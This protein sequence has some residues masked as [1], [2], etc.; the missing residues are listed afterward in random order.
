MKHT[1]RET[2]VLIAE[3]GKMISQGFSFYLPRMAHFLQFIETGA[4]SRDSS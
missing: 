1:V 3:V 2:S 4:D